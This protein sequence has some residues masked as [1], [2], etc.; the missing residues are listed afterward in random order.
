M[1]DHVK[2]LRSH[3]AYKWFE[4]RKIKAFYNAVVTPTLRIGTQVLLQ[5][6][7]HLLIKEKLDTFFS[8]SSFLFIIINIIGNT[9]NAIISEIAIPALIISPRFLTG[10][11]LDNT[12]E[13]KPV[14]V[15][16]IAK[17]EGESFDS[18]VFITSLY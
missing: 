2:N 14:I 8:C 12:S 6:L 3:G 18:T 13:A 5:V 11:I 9:K 7:I 17:N 16:I 4:S 1:S 15:V 10:C